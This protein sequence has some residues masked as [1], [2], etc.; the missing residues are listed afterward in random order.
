DG[1]EVS[2]E[3]I[4]EEAGVRRGKSG[5]EDA[6]RP[7]PRDETPGVLRRERERGCE[8]AAEIAADP[9]HDRLGRPPL[10][11]ALARAVGAVLENVE[12]EGGEVDGAE[13]DGRAI[14]L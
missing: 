1:A 6:A 13:L 3:G 14:D 7:M 10:G 11:P 5:E 4:G 12:V 2:F 8:Q 9:V